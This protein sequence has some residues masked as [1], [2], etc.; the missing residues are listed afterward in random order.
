MASKQ[1]NGGKAKAEGK[2]EK[3]SIAPKG[4]MARTGDP[5]VDTARA[6]SLDGDTSNDPAGEGVKTTAEKAGVEAEGEDDVATPSSPVTAP[7]GSA[8]NADLI[9]ELD[10]VEGASFEAYTGLVGE[11][12]TKRHAGRVTIRTA[13]GT[14]YEFG[15]SHP[16]TARQIANAFTGIADELSRRRA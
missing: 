5:D 6:R 14:E 7:S 4:T 2:S 8:E 11:N 15:V 16:D 13:D 12:Q 9:D 3:A 1:T 10:M